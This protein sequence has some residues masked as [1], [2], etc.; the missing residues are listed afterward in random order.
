MRTPIVIVILALLPLSGRAAEPA[1][2]TPHWSLELKGGM[3][4]PAVQDWQAYYGQHDMAEYAASLAYKVLPWFE[5]GAGAGT[6]TAKGQSYYKG[7]GTPAGEMTYELNPLD[8]FMMVRGAVK[9]NQ[10]IM[11]YLGGGWT[12][13]YYR[14]KLPGQETVRGS[15]DGYHVRGGLQISLDNID[16]SASTRMFSHY[17]VYGTY[18]FIEAA[19]YHVL[20]RTT[21]ID[22]GGTAYFGGL[23]FEF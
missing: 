18:V 1:L 5:L 17:G 21:S 19:Y 11:P 8:V 15:A 20:E 6:M 3:F 14:E 12:R 10:W 4:V 23:L 7:H 16:P 2:S 9:E 22:L 13:M